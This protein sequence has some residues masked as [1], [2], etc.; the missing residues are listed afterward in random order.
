MFFF[1]KVNPKISE[2]CLTE[3]NRFYDENYVPVLDF[4]GRCQAGHRT[5]RRRR[6]WAPPP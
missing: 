4:G 6:L 5:G 1:K 2:Y 3:T